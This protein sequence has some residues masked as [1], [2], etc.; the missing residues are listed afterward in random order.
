MPPTL[1]SLW[2]SDHTSFQ[3]ILEMDIPPFTFRE[4]DGLLRFF[5]DSNKRKGCPP[6]PYPW[7][8][9][10]TKAN[11]QRPWGRKQKPLWWPGGK[12]HFSYWKANQL[13]KSA[14]LKPFLPAFLSTTF[15]Q[16]CSPSILSELHCQPLFSKVWADKILTCLP[17]TQK[18]FI[19]TSIN[20][21]SSKNS[22]DLLSSR[23]TEL[24]NNEEGDI[25]SILKNQAKW[26]LIC[27]ANSWTKHPTH[28]C[29]FPLSGRD[30]RGGE[31]LPLWIIISTASKA[32][33]CLAKRNP[34]SRTIC[35]SNTGSH[36][37]GML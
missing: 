22:K 15:P 7:R 24:P 8:Q 2:R 14:G 21:K 25:L 30:T 37:R 1:T 18:S 36:Q 3:D 10:T 16:A 13:V 4:A 23:I 12:M 27:S 26:E 35:F 31:I 6:L 9:S 11:L 29:T 19:G 32:R 34:Y 5:E 17:T 33:L 28:F 20:R